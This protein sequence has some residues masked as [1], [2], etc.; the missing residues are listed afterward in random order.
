MRRGGAAAEG[1]IERR[2]DDL[3][4]RLTRRNKGFVG[5]LVVVS[6]RFSLGTT[7]MLCTLLR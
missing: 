4:F 6:S 7:G 3:F 1:E 2:G 5:N